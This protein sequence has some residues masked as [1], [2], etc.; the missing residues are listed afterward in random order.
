[1]TRKIN[2]ADKFAGAKIREL[3]TFKGMTRNDLACLVDVTHQQLHKYENG[4]NRISVGR[5]SNIAR[6]LK[7]PVSEFF[8]GEVEYVPTDRQKRSYEVTKN[9]LKMKD[10]K[11]QEAVN[12]LIRTLI[13]EV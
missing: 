10:P 6:A 2:E 7:T 13:K 3:R 11:Q 12:I 1:M 5:L 4:T 9:F 8:E